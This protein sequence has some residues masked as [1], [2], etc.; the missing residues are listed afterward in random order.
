MDGIYQFELWGSPGGSSYGGKGGYTVVP[1]HLAATK[2]I[3]VIVGGSGQSV[4]PYETAG[5]YNGGGISV[6]CLASPDS[7]TGGGMTHIS[8]T[9]NVA[10]STAQKIRPTGQYANPQYAP[11]VMGYEWSF[12][13]YW[14]PSGTIAIAGGGGGALGPQVTSLDSNYCEMLKRN[15]G[16][17]DDSMAQMVSVIGPY[18][19]TFW[20]HSG[21]GV[22]TNSLGPGAGMPTLM[23]Y[24]YTVPGASNTSGGFMQGVGQGCANSCGAGGGW[25]GGYSLAQVTSSG[26][27]QL[28]GMSC[29][30]FGSGGTSYVSS[31]CYANDYS[32]II[33]LDRG[34]SAAVPIKPDVNTSNNGYTKVTLLR[35]N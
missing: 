2:T 34:S 21:G 15:A 5:G 4:T 6:T 25:Q 22:Y 13:G 14:N 8:Y 33:R 1:V 35:R 28:L 30:K 17:D 26:R 7:S 32:N 31:E 29:A 10:R 24:M 16:F 18:V 27:I 23:S 19:N 20:D 3:Y 11:G 12:G 9:A